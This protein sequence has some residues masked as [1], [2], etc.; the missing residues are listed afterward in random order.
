MSL[1]SQKNESQNLSV[2]E[3]V[4]MLRTHH[5]VSQVELAE[6]M[7]VKKE[8]ISYAER[9]DAE[10]TEEHLKSI[11]ERFDIVGLPLTARE[12]V[13]FRERLYYWRDLI[14]AKRMEEARA[15]HKEMFNIYNLE[16]C[17]PEMVMLYRMIEVKFLVAEGNNKSATEKLDIPQKRID[18]MSDENKFH[19]WNNKGALYTYQGC[20]EEGLEFLLKAYK[21]MGNNEAL[22]YE[23]DG[24]LYYAIAMCYTYIEIPHHAITF[25]Q[26]ARQ[27]YPTKRTTRFIL[28]VEQGLALNYVKINQLDD[29]ETLLNKCLIM[30]ESIKGENYLSHTL[31]CYGYMHKKAKNWGAAVEYF[32]KALN[33]A[34]KG[35]VDYYPCIYHKI[36]CII[37]TR[38]FTKAGQLLEQ[39]KNI[40]KNDD[41]WAVYFE[42]LGHYLKISRRMTSN[43]N[44]ESIEYIENIAIPYFIKM[45]DYLNA[46]E[47]YLLLEQHHEK[48]KRIMQSLLMTKAILD[49]YTRCYVNLKREIKL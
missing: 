10:Y 11:K 23:D 22:V 39:V 8:R 35:S 4:L 43:E 14:R 42:A 49:I 13:A 24:A 17:D 38:A 25:W 26:K 29:A 16:P 28:R 33:Y 19:F 20:C 37:H 45:H 44:D 18:E 27:A 7:R 1:K 5:K 40:C 36:Q 12:C 9:G 48:M 32:D 34:P 3:K 47:Y 41:V 6:F 21:L 15:I 2:A 30:A 31:F 46:V